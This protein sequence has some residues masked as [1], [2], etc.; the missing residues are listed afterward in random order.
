MEY[1]RILG[2]PSEA[3]TKSTGKM[4]GINLLNKFKVCK[5]CVIGKAQQTNVKKKTDT[6]ATAKGVFRVYNP[7]TQNISLSRDVIWT[8]QV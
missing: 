6:K 8:K 7:I 3:V 2:H 4:N 5:S 1:H